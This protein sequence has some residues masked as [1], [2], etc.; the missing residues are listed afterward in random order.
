[1]ARV[2]DADDLLV[3][4]LRTMLA[5]ERASVDLLGRLHADA[6]D[7]QLRT[8]LSRHRS[9]TEEHA[10]TVETVLRILGAEAVPVDSPAIAGFEREHRASMRG[11]DPQAPV[12]IRNL[13][14]AGSA[15]HVE[16][17]EIGSYES[18]IEKAELMG[19]DDAVELLQESLHTEEDALDAGKQVSSRLARSLIE[20][21]ARA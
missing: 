13:V 6:T 4:E 18:A 16:L 19:E 5:V 17:Y 11:I 8:A 2:R 3:L 12:G 15:A 14:V 20:S 21:P 9:E 1:M 10:K 7:E